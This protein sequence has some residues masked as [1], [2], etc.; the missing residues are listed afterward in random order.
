MYF[1]RMDIDLLHKSPPW[2][3]ELS[4]TN[5]IQII[6]HHNMR[7]KCLLAEANLQSIYLRLF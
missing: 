4:L 7:E 2:F 1:R 6:K 3:N 5:Q